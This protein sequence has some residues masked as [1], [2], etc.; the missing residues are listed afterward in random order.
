MRLA[1]ILYNDK[2][3]YALV[4]NDGI[5]PLDRLLKGI[6]LDL[7]TFL[8]KG[9]SERIQKALE[10]IPDSWL[11]EKVIPFD[12]SRI[13]CPVTE[14]TKIICLGKNYLEHAKETGSKPPK[15]PLLFSK[16]SSALC[17]AYDD[18][19]KWHNVILMDYEV[20][21]GVI[22]GKQAKN[23]KAGDAMDHVFG[24]TI[25]NDVSC[26][27]MQKGERQ[28]FRGKSLDTFCPVGPFI[29]TREEVPN[30]HNLRLQSL[31]NG[32]VRQDS[33]TAEFIFD[34]PTVIEDISSVMTL[35]PG[36]LIATGTPSGVALG[37]AVDLLDAVLSG[38]YMDAI[39]R[40]ET[41]ARK[42]SRFLQPG[43][44]VRC[45]IDGLGYQEN[46]IIADTNE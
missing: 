24:Y 19:V 3:S 29:A 32:E 9:W 37:D 46:R 27:E 23:I 12:K 11:K 15:R 40:D 26:R 22:I 7:R 8:F 34:I 21:L 14:P 44:T 36:D 4:V 43:M 42:Y 5:L 28:W 39:L 20:E 17:S 33:T 30:P 1:R 31:V 41:L 13:L 25:V 45:Q 35:M 10:K 2:A 6:P 16:A 38:D 18:I